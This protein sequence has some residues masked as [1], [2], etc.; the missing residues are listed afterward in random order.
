M[1]RR[2]IDNKNATPIC[3]AKGRWSDDIVFNL[4]VCYADKMGRSIEGGIVEHQNLERFTASAADVAPKDQVDLMARCWFSLT[5]GRIDSIQHEYVD[6]KTGASETVRV[7]GHPE[8]GIA[9]IYDQ[10]L[11]IFAISQWIDAHRMGIAVSRRV[12]FTPYQFFAWV[13]REPSGSQYQRLKEALHRLKTT[14]IETTIRANVGKRTRN[15][16]RQFSWISEWEITEEEGEV[17]GIEVVLAEWLFESIQDFHVLT[18][19]KRYFEIHGGVERWLY[20]YARKATG[21]P[22]GTWKETF[23]SLYKK[24][25]SQQAYKHYANALRKLV[26]KNGL[27][28]L[29]LEKTKSTSGDD[30][31]L[32][33]RTD[34]REAVESKPKAP[35]E[36]A[37]LVLIERTPLEDAWENV[38]EI[39]RRHLGEATANSWL[40]NLRLQGLEE[41]LLTLKAPTK[42]IADWVSSHYRHKLM[43]AWRS[44]G[45]DIRELNIEGPKRNLA[46]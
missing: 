26:E 43:D 1:G 9:T 24:S 30:M 42:F 40:A 45:H 46:A 11:L 25:A 38:L 7:S 14:T 16:V 37:Q 5:P 32:M 12:H 22:N 3:N 4:E 29:R 39:M 18:L 23:K 44:V 17:R 31:L 36:E 34:K 27:P 33:E 19:D 2:G 10:D 41:G 21:G 35:K 6:G 13:N 28:G 20:L 8:H 15:R